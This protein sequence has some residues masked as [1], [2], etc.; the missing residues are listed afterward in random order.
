MKSKNYLLKKSTG[1][2]II[3]ISVAVLGVIS[4]FIIIVGLAL[5][6]GLTGNNS[7]GGTIG[8]LSGCSNNQLS[9]NQKSKIENNKPVYQ[10]AAEKSGIPWQFLASLHLRETN[11]ADTPSNNPGDGPFQIQGAKYKTFGVDSATEAGEK[12][13]SLVK[14]FYNKDL[15]KTSNEDTIKLAFLAYNRGGMYVEGGCSWNQSPYVMN[16]FDAQHTN[17]VWPNNTCEPESVRGKT[18]TQLGTFTVYSAL[19]GCSISG[20]TALPINPSHLS[21]YPYNNSFHGR[22]VSYSPS[23]PGHNVILCPNKYNTN[24]SCNTTGE[25]VDLR[26]PGGT[27]VYAPFDSKVVFSSMSGSLCGGICG[28][29]IVIQSLDGK[30]AAVLAHLQNYVTQGSTVSAGQRIGELKEYP[31]GFGPHL[32]FE[33]WSNN[34]PIHAGIGSPSQVIPNIWAA[35]KKV[36]GF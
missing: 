36:L 15:S 17:M 27:E 23:K 18:N 32:H 3:L 31:G 9:I 34:L 24:I 1:S 26:A 22:S 12:A 14:S 33:L 30:S 11:L 10:V 28:G 21:S 6:T 19:V 5:M 2:T 7:G 13:K 20:K 25:A 29:F 8:S 16:Q 4:I 35:Q